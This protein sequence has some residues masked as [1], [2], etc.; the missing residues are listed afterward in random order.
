MGN[1]K[2]R[3]RRTAIMRQ[4]N[5]R[6]A[7]AGSALPP[8]LV[9]EGENAFTIQAALLPVPDR[10]YDADC[11]WAERKGGAVSL[12]FAKQDRDSPEALRS[13]L[14]VR[15]PIDSFANFW[16]HSREFYRRLQS[17]I[18]SSD[19]L[20]EPIVKAREMHSEKDHSDWATICVVALSGGQAQVDFFL[21][22]QGDVF[23]YKRAG[24]R[25]RLE[26][27][28]IV[29][30]YTTP[31]QMEVLFDDSAAMFPAIEGAISA[32]VAQAQEDQE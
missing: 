32:W 20:K 23:L 30:V 6:G 1:R 8:Y 4:E 13:R 16:E 22:A 27:Q 25:R 15:M 2:S 3:Q 7:S 21:L 26:A 12:F 10:T 17:S 18:R 5:H 28:P 11:A 9:P 19:A 14:E 31:A 29:R 24:N